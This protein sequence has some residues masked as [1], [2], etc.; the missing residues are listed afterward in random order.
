M[1]RRTHNASSTGSTTSPPAMPTAVPV[2]RAAARSRSARAPSRAVD[3]PARWESSAARPWA[4]RAF[5]ASRSTPG[6]R[7]P[8]VRTV[9]M[10]GSA[11]SVRHREARSSTTASAVVSSGLG[12]AAARARRPATADSCCRRPSSS[13]ARKVGLA[14][15]AKPRTA[16]SWLS[17]PAVSSWALT[18]AGSSWST[19]VTR[20]EDSWVRA[21]VPA[22]MAP[23]AS[24]P[25]IAP[26]TSNQ[27]R[28]DRARDLPPVSVL[29]SSA[30]PRFSHVAGF[31]VRLVPAHRRRHVTCRGTGSP[32]VM[33]P[34]GTLSQITPRV[35]AASDRGRLRI[36]GQLWRPGPGR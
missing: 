12:L 33:P 15:I 20:A 11:Y 27:P 14:V 18:R 6:P 23:A 17:R 10:V 5:P 26:T 25:A 32:V 1:V 3:N 24:T 4:T 34:W 19:T 35:D 36:P 7:G 31:P 2:S 13:G 29:F 9:A 21:R 8:P 22:T 28:N 30:S 16:V